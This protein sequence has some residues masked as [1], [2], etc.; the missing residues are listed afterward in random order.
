MP[1]TDSTWRPICSST[2]CNEDRNQ[3]SWDCQGLE[4]GS[5]GDSATDRTGCF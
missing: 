3:V 2:F 5:A 1:F 4:P